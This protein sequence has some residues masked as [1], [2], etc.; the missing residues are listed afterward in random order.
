M[1]SSKPDI[2]L[3]WFHCNPVAWLARPS[4]SHSRTIIAL[5]GEYVC[6]FLFD[7][8]SNSSRR[9]SHLFVV[10]E[11][12]GWKYDIISLDQPDSQRHHN[13]P[14]TRRYRQPRA[15]VAMF[16][17]RPPGFFRVC[18]ER[19]HCSQG[20]CQWAVPLVNH[21]SYG[22]RM[23]LPCLE[24]NL[25]KIGYNRGLRYAPIV[26]VF[27]GIMIFW[28]PWQGLIWFGDLGESATAMSCRVVPDVSGTRHRALQVLSSVMNFRPRTGGFM[29]NYVALQV[30]S[31]SHLILF[32]ASYP[33]LVAVFSLFV[34]ISL[35]SH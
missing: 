25:P 15:W 7:P 24:A 18:S 31:R 22:S 23:K 30:T 21:C 2:V 9:S 27:E 17:T 4:K 29:V 32:M 13:E 14:K 34:I 28:I 6:V 33:S 35:F 16:S 10:I 11:H 26:K 8:F 20:L 19:V 1:H 12:D 5:L 3:H